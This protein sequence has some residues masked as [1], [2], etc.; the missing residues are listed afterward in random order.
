MKRI[1]SLALALLLLCGTAAAALADESNGDLNTF[2]PF[3]AVNL[4]NS[5]QKSLLDL[6][7]EQAAIVDFTSDGVH[8]GKLVYSNLL[9]DAI[10]MFD[11]GSEF[12]TASTVYLY[13][14]LKDESTLKNIPMLVWAAVVQMGYYGE[15]EETGSSFLEWVNEERT[16]GEIF[17]SPYFIAYYSEEPYEYS[18][19]LLMRQ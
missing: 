8:D 6:T 13:C 19:L 12:E 11:A 15:I 2:C 7:D 17:T 10:L 16:N 9:G 14:S 3:M 1:L 18:S 4:L 5:M